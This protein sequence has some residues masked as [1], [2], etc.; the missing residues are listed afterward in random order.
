MRSFCNKYIH[1]VWYQRRHAWVEGIEFVPSDCF[2]LGIVVK[3]VNDLRVPT[4]HQLLFAFFAVQCHVIFQMFYVNLSLRP[5]E[6]TVMI[7]KSG[8]IWLLLLLTVENQLK[9]EPWKAARLSHNRL[10]SL[11][12]QA[13]TFFTP[14]TGNIIK[15]QFHRPLIAVG[16][17]KSDRRLLDTHQETSA[18]DQ[19]SHI[20]TC[21]F[22]LSGLIPSSYLSGTGPSPGFRSR[23]GQKPH[24]AAQF[25]NR[26]LDVSS[27]L[28]AN[29]KWGQR[30]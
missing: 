28:G 21:Q 20:L 15:K 12:E 6:K 5:G 29:M 26:I 17:F 18:S 30:F 3:L 27:N 7:A 23:G 10:I 13:A 14:Q 24:A 16:R 8:R 1:L 4:D 22:F 19:N 2:E 11:Q 25:F 9:T